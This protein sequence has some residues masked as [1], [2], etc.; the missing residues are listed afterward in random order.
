[1]LREGEVQ[2]KTWVIRP[3]GGGS[4]RISVGR[5]MIVS[6][7]GR[8]ILERMRYRWLIMRRLPQP[9]QLILTKIPTIPLR[10]RISTSV[11]W[12]EETV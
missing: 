6:V 10:L 12:M 4:P 5:D 8:L 7:E 1:M 3:M 2:L 11:M 9:T